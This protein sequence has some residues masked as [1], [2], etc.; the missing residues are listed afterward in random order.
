MKP[1]TYLTFVVFFAF[2][3]IVIYN[4]GI[5]KEAEKN[6]IAPCEDSSQVFQEIKENPNKLDEL[7]IE[8]CTDNQK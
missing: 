1:I 6:V 4:K 7:I 3:S 5:S 8:K 2:I